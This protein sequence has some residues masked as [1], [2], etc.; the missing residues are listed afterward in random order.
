MIRPGVQAPVLDLIT[1]DGT[2]VGRPWE[3][4]ACI[5]AFFKVTCPVCQMA[6]PKITALAGTGSRVLAIGQDPAPA[7]AAFARRWNQ[8]VP[9]LSEP[10]PYPASD[11]YGVEAVPTLVLV[12]TGGVVLDAVA[13]WDRERWNALSVAAGGAPVSSPEDGLPSYRPG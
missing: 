10:S 13:G 4:G 2:V 8:D 6:A 1:P 3:D 9:T 12:G 7:L 11:A 5:L